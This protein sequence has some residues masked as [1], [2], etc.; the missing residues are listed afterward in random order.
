M[1]KEPRFYKV[2]RDGPVIIWKFDNPP[3]NMLTNETGAELDEL[4]E[5]FEA[6]PDLRVAIFTGAPRGIFVHHI[7]VSLFVQMSAALRTVSADRP[8]QLPNIGATMGTVIQRHG[9]KPIICA[10]N[11]PTTAGG[12]LL[13]L[14]CDFR[15]MARN[16]TIGYFVVDIGILPS[17][18]QVARLVGPAKALEILMLG[19]PIDADEAER[20]GLVHYACDLEELMPAALKFAKKLATKP[21]LTLTH[22]KRCIYEGTEMPLEESLALQRQLE[23]EGL[24]SDD[25]FRLLSEYVANGQNWESFSG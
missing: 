2:E 17:V 18:R 25:A 11:G 8:P 9:P 15:F 3:R 6:D 1:E 23:Q 22:I 19:K 7:D 12:T 21:P 4:V 24:R 14:N 16:A 20:I 10:I 5:A 13:A